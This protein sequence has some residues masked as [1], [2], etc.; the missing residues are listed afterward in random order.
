M[1]LKLGPQSNNDPDEASRMLGIETLLRSIQEI[2]RKVGGLPEESLTTHA[3]PTTT[4]TTTSDYTERQIKAG[5]K[6][7]Q[8]KNITRRKIFKT[9]QWNRHIHF[10][11]I[12]ESK[13]RLCFALRSENSS[14]NNDGFD[15]KYFWTAWPKNQD[16][17]S[18]LR[19]RPA[20]GLEDRRSFNQRISKASHSAETIRE[21]LTSPCSLTSDTLRL[22]L[23]RHQA[24][25]C[26]RAGGSD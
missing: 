16:F 20:V 17:G 8:A 18:N 19:E 13:R 23:H 7:S 5:E 22:P 4:P 10:I 25:S 12:N 6:S 11:G 1:R 21:P 2:G 26:R 3:K 9:L 24:R 14:H 15:P